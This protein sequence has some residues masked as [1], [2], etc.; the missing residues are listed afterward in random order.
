MR[1][2]ATPRWRDILTARITALTVEKVKGIFAPAIRVTL[3]TISNWPQT[4][5]HG[6]K[7]VGT[8]NSAVYA[9]L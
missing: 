7:T 4:P 6:K 2:A 8:L 5:D 3:V 9:D 1:A